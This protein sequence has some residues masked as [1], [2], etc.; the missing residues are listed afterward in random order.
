MA[1]TVAELNARLTA[2]TKDFTSAIDKAE[3]S[4][5]EKFQ[6]IG[7]KMSKFVTLPLVGVGVAAFKASSDMQ[8]SMSKVTVVF[9]EQAK[10]ITA[11]SKTAAKGLGI[12][13]QEAL[14]AAGTFGNLFRAM[15][16]ATPAAA[17]MSKE[18]I[19]LA[20]DLASF[21]NAN[22]EETLNALR[23]GLVGET[24]PL[25]RFG[26]NLNQARI[27]AEALALGLAKPPKEMAKITIASTALERAQVAVAKAT[28]EHGA[29]SLEARSAMATQEAAQGRLTKALAGGTVELDAGQKAQAAF[30]LIMKDS[31]LAQGDFSRTADGAANQQR[32]LTAQV[33]DA[34][35][36]LGTQLLPIGEKIIGMLSGL[37]GKFGEL[38]NSQQTMI[39]VSGG[40]VAA[41]G[42]VATAIGAVTT[43]I[44]ASRVAILAHPFAFAVAA[45]VAVAEAS[46]RVTGGFDG[47]KGS[48]LD[49]KATVIDPI[50]RAWQGWADTLDSINRRIRSLPGAGI[51]GGGGGGGL[52]GRLPFFHQGGVV[53]GPRGADV[54]IM[55]QAGETVIP[56]GGGGGSQQPVVVQLVADGRVIQ[57][58]LLAHQR[59]SGALGLT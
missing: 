5:G 8:E 57:E 38:T 29:N 3:K 11:W 17:D 39:L 35:A 55:A 51:F 2:D 42:P 26:V 21:N 32:I 18:M 52:F 40:V 50:T 23:S 31:A 28:K 1:L 19:G 7:K 14:E 44:T 36:A 45:L 41:L 49:L 59:R 37:A 16:I 10:E 54:P 43:A 22:P 25:R 56:A 34:A 48:L 53:P 4:A 24:E 46:E 15:N 12:S 30:S 20:S 27:E 58:I 9:G 47:M 13:Q 33:K 6:D